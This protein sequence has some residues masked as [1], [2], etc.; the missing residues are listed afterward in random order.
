MNLNEFNG[1]GVVD[2]SY[3]NEQ[4]AEE[5]ELDKKLRE[6]QAELDLERE[7]NNKYGKEEMKTDVKKGFIANFNGVC[8]HIAITLAS[9][10]FLVGSLG[11]SPA[12]TNQ[13][14]T[15]QQTEAAETVMVAK[16]LSEKSGALGDGF[17]GTGGVI[18]GTKYGEIYIPGDTLENAYRD[19]E[20]SKNAQVAAYQVDVSQK[21]VEHHSVDD[22]AVESGS[23][24]RERVNQ[25]T[26]D[27]VSYDIE[28]SQ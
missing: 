12:A 15:T 11:P 20:A 14:R 19:Y 28:L 25:N 24:V 17:D 21:G 4:I 9:T 6:K 23:V 18:I 16:N 1:R 13:Q 8:S 7:N 26:I 10:A 3:I 2:L 27:T 22:V 5:R